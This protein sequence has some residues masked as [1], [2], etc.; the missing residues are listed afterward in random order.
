[1]APFPLVAAFISRNKAAVI[2]VSITVADILVSSDAGHGSDA[3]A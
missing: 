1:M 3:D 2:P